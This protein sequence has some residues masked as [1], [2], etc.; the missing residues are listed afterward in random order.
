MECKTT[1]F[2][3]CSKKGTSISSEKLF[4][5]ACTL[6]YKG[7]NANTDRELHQ[8]SFLIY[9][10]QIANGSLQGPYEI[11]HM[12]V[13]PMVIFLSFFEFNKARRMTLTCRDMNPTT[14]RGQMYH[15]QAEAESSEILSQQPNQLV[16]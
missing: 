12:H 10:F 8:T 5:R 4:E 2:Y 13:G 6:K 3:E 1:K 14:F 15:W 9:M 11:A 7:C 16:T